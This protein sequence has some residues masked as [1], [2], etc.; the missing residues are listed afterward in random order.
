MST[1]RP[2]SVL[3]TFLCLL[4][5]PLGAQQG[6]APPDA[7]HVVLISLDG[8]TARALQDP[9]IPLPNLRRLAAAGATAKAMQ[10]VNPTV[11]WANHTSMV[12][13]VTPAGHG[14]VYN[15]LLVR[16]PGAAP[17]IEQWRDRDEMVHA[18]TLYDAVHQK[19]MTTAQ[20][21]WVAIW[22][23]PTVTWEFRERVD[24]ANPV[25]QALV[26]QKLI[27]QEDLENFGSRNIVFRDRAWTDAAKQI[28]REH[29]PHLMMFH[30]LTL[31][32][33]QHRYGPDTLAAQS[34]MAHLDSLVG[35]IVAAVD[36]AGLTPRTTFVVAS[37]HGFRKV[38][39]QINPNVALA[40]A[41]LIEVSNGKAAKVEGWVVPEG[42]TAIG[43]VTVDDPDGSRLAK[44]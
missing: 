41:G 10:P 34:T 29:Q 24:P 3:A 39:Q 22:N 38:E 44:M 42:G 6:T 32:S 36:E 37:D 33:V 27:T 25:S 12:T 9:A 5:I 43:Y 31:D 15:G 13:G 17:H 2:A 28:I 40:R 30:L 11:T 23:A 21:D 16:E 19:G 18:P 14:V 8:F 20:V 35:E 4:V 7:P 1:R 26:A